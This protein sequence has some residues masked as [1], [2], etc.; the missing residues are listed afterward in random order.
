MRWGEGLQ[1][2]TPQ[3]HCLN[4][5][6][7]QISPDNQTLALITPD[8]LSLIN[9]FYGDLKHL[10]SFPILHTELFLVSFWIP[11]A[12][13]STSGVK[14][15]VRLSKYIS[16]HTPFLSLSDLRHSKRKKIWTKFK[17]YFWSEEIYVSLPDLSYCEKR[18]RGSLIINNNTRVFWGQ[19]Y[20]IINLLWEWPRDTCIIKSKILQVWGGGQNNASLEDFQF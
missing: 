14:I 15:V 18:G 3:S 19:N 9:W 13:T 11:L 12:T 1:L 8:G 5:P 20:E 16:H 2:F 7:H 6:K 4:I 17:I 10:E